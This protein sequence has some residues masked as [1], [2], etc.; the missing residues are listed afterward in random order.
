MRRWGS[1]FLC[2]GLGLLAAGCPKGKPVFNQGKKAEDLQDYDAALAFYQKA[3]KAD[4]HNVNFKIRLN[5]VRFE[6]GEFH[7]KQGLAFRKKG[8]LQAAA[9]EF[10]RAETIDPSSPVAEQEL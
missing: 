4:P 3:L 8:D 6:A 9:G 5:Q 2:A 7:I 10:Q 1:L